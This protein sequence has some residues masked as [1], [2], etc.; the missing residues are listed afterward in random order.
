MPKSLHIRTSLN[1]N[2]KNGIVKFVKSAHFSA[3]GA[4]IKRWYNS[5]TE[6]NRRKLS[7][8]FDKMKRNAKPNRKGP[9]K[10]LL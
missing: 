9:A 4:A 6:S 1:P 5:P 2:R 10:Q 8:A 7:A 3:Y